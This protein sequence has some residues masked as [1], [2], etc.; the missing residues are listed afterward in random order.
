MKDASVG[1]VLIVVGVALSL[2]A[3]GDTCPDG[4]TKTDA[5]QVR[6]V[7]EAYRSSWLRGDPAGV[8]ATLTDDA[9]LL[10][11]HGAAPIVGKAAITRYWW[12][13]G[14]PV[15]TVTRLDITVEGLSGDCRMAT[16]YGNDDVGWT[17]EDNGTVTAHGHPGTYLNVFR[18]SAEGQWRISRHMWDDGPSRP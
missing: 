17:Q 10:P 5:A 18:K 11:A 1:R 4:L 13:A 8:L 15:T 9:V 16:A 6:A 14:A 12:P 7:V 3:W 2:P